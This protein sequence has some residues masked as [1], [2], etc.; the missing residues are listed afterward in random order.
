MPGVKQEVLCPGDPSVLANQGGRSRSSTLW[1]NMVPSGELTNVCLVAP[2]PFPLSGCFLLAKPSQKPA[3]RM[4]RLQPQPTSRGTSRGKGWRPV[5][6]GAGLL[7]SSLQWHEEGWRVGITKPGFWPQLGITWP[8]VHPFTFL[9]LNFFICKMN[10]G[11]W[12][13]IPVL[14]AHVPTSQAC[15]SLP[16]QE[17][18][19]CSH[20]LR[21]LPRTNPNLKLSLRFHRYKPEVST[22]RD[23]HSTPGSN[24]KWPSLKVAFLNSL[25]ASSRC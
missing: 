10:G 8:S 3:G 13:L 22:Q 21:G 6:E 4:R 17:R 9:G 16:S 14:G 19:E 5:L 2:P 11:M 25:G 1:T 7:E 20:M 18:G 24:W 23:T 12:L 15:G